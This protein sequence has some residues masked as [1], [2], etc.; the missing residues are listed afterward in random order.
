MSPGSG[1]RGEGASSVTEILAEP[2]SAPSVWR[3]D[4]LADAGG[5]IIRFTEEDFADF[6]RALAHVS[7]RRLMDVTEIR[8][9]DFP[10][11]HFRQR[12]DDIVDRLEQGLGLVLLRGLPTYDRFS[13]DE[14]TM[15]YWGMGQHM[16]NFVPQNRKAT[17]S[18]ISETSA[19]A[20]RTSGRTQPTKIWG[21]TPTP[22]TSRA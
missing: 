13:V 7:K 22:P 6:E 18:A 17:S 16:G 5:W 21:S 12:I 9:E 10:L 11:P 19:G 1:V 2:V 3:G 15:I 8:A 4:E 14:A 20:A